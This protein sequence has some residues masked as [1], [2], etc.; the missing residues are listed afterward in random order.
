[1]RFVQRV[2][3]SF[4]LPCHAT[5]HQFSYTTLFSFHQKLYHPSIVCSRKIETNM[6]QLFST[7]S[8]PVEK[9]TKPCVEETSRETIE[10][11]FVDKSGKEIP[12]SATIGK[13]LLEIAHENHIE[14][15]GKDT[16]FLFFYLFAQSCQSHS[17]SNRN[18][19]NK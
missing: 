8:G 1:M 19:H 7:I 6:L 10:F 9:A 2:V 11:V 3:T 14:L 5:H 17:N 15:E 12:V 16:I 4:R 13:N 18:T